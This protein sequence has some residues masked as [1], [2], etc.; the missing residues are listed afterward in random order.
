MSENGAHHGPACHEIMV[1]HVRNCVLPS[2]GGV[3]DC[4]HISDVRLSR[5]GCAASSHRA[6]AECP[7]PS[8][9][10]PGTICTSGFARL[11]IQRNFDATQLGSDALGS[12]GIYK[13]LPPL[14]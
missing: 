2:G 8:N 14:Q 4:G 9:L 13:I 12:E 3:V 7:H 11:L 5:A 6:R 10:G 1:L